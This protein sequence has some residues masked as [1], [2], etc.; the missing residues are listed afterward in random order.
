MNS[1]CRIKLNG[2]N[3]GEL[4]LVGVYVNDKNSL[5]AFPVPCDMD[6][7]YMQNKTLASS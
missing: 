5:H 6:K 7:L 1:R 4:P 2:N 3:A